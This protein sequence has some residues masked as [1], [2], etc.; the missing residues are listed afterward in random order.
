[1]AATSMLD[2]SIID[3]VRDALGDTAYRGFAASLLAEI[4][5]LGP[6]LDAHLQAGAFETLAQTAHRSAGSAVSVGAAGI[7]SLLKDIEDQA[8]SPDAAARLPGLL[9]AL[10]DRLSQTRS[11]IAALVGPV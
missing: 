5:A 11:A 10:P 2:V 8:R 1:M 4:A 6:Q 9:A 7:H 3:E